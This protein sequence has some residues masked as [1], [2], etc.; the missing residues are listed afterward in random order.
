MAINWKKDAKICHCVGR[1]TLIKRDLRNNI[2]TYKDMEVFSSKFVW[3]YLYI[4]LKYEGG[5]VSCPIFMSTN[6]GSSFLD[7][8]RL[9]LQV[10]YHLVMNCWMR[11]S[12]VGNAV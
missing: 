8:N 6:V 7:E 4:A 2:P 1:S 11:G 5:G 12:S 9:L 3:H 10:I